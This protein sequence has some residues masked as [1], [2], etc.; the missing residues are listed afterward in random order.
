MAMRQ[1]NTEERFGQPMLIVATEEEDIKHGID[2]WLKGKNPKCQSLPIAF[3]WRGI[4]ITKY[5]QISIRSK[6]F[7]GYNKCEID[8]LRQGETL[9]KLYIFEFTDCWIICKMLDIIDWLKQNS[10]EI[11]PNYDHSL[12]S[13]GYIS[14]D[15]IPHLLI[16]KGSP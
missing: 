11:V 1:T 15:C 3:R 6:V 8:K 14:I 16:Q 13:G 4:P 2:C 7:D 5:Q 10:P 12:T 9:A